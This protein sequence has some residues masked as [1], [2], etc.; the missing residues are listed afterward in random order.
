ME[1]FELHNLPFAVALFVLA[2][3]LL[4]QLIGASDF[5]DFN[6]DTEF[7][8]D[9]DLD[10]DSGMDSSLST[11]SVII[12]GMVS[13]L[14]LG[15]VP[16]LIWFVCFL[17]I[18]AA[19][20]VSVQSFAI[21]ATGFPLSLWLVAPAATAM[22]LPLT[23][24]ISR[25]LGAIIPEDE[26]TAVG[27]DSLLRRDATISIGAAQTGRPARAS[28]KDRH[29]HTHHVMVEPNDQDA[30]LLE[31]ETVL[32]TRREGERFFAVQYENSNLSL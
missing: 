11:D 4:L 30:I 32:L 12:G 6:F 27:L 24:L 31:G 20:G 10:T 13:L 25:P 26:T 28:V 22:A 18:F 23:G 5:L 7:D 19:I 9:M 3:L 29:G 8:M 14:G 16:F 2:F 17:A 21:D 1:I 15:K